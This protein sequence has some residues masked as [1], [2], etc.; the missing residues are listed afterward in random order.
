MP[1]DIETDEATAAASLSDDGPACVDRFYRGDAVYRNLYRDRIDFRA[2]AR[3]DANLAAVLKNGQIDFHDPT[4]VVQLTKTLVWRDFGLHI[5][6]PA[7]RLCPPVPNR[8][9]YILWLKGLLDSTTGRFGDGGGDD[10][11]ASRTVTGLDIG[12]GASCIYPLLGCAQRP[13]W[14]F[15]ATDVDPASL[16]C[17]R[18]NVRRN[19]LQDRICVVERPASTDAPLISLAG[20]D[21]GN[22]GGDGVATTNTPFLPAALDFVMVN[23][24]FYASEEDMQAAA[25]QKQQPP[26]SACTGTPVEMV[27]APGGEVAF[28]GRLLAESAVLRTRVAWYTSLLGRLASVAAVVGQLRAAGV[29]NYAVAAFVQGR[30]TRRWAVAWSYGA[31]RPAV[32][33]LALVGG[34]SSSIPGHDESSG[35]GGLN[36]IKHLLPPN[37]DVDAVW[38]MPTAEP[39]GNNTDNGGVS[40]LASRINTIVGALQLVSWTWDAQTLR[41]AGR[42][43]ENVWGRAW[44]RKNR[45]EQQQDGAMDTGPPE[46]ETKSS[47]TSSQAAQQEGRSVAVE[48]SPH[49]G[50]CAF[51]FVVAIRVGITETVVSCRWTEG[52]SEA[53]FQSFSTPSNYTTTSKDLTCTNMSGGAGSRFTA[54]NQTT[55]Q[56]LSTQTAGLVELSDF[57]KRR[58]EVIEQQEREAR[59]AAQAG[60]GLPD[61]SQ[62]GTPT[63]DKG[64]AS[65]ASGGE[66]SGTA[67]GSDA[68]SSGL[69]TQE[70]N[71]K[72]K[73]KKDGTDGNDGKTGKDGKD[74]R[75]HKHGKV[76]KVSKL[77]FMGDEDEGD[78]EEEKEAETEEDGTE[79]N[80]T[81]RRARPSST[82]GAG[83]PDGSGAP[84]LPV[85]RPPTIPFVFYEGANIPGGVVRVRKGDHVW[86]FLDRSRKVGARLGVGEK[87][88]SK[89]RLHWARINV[90]DL[91]LVRGNLIIPH[92]YDIYFFLIN[93]TIGPGG[94]RVFDYS[95][96]PPPAQGAA[97]ASSDDAGATAGAIADTAAAN[98]LSTPDADA[99][100]EEDF[101][102]LEGAQDDPSLTKVVDRRWYERNKHIYPA[103]VWQEF[104]PEADYTQQV[105]RDQGG[106]AFFFAKK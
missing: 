13:N 69:A 57:R 6:L 47:K 21:D 11:N 65:G 106:N 40:R 76:I 28:V 5:V 60:R 38:S 24:P 72:K 64:G 37:T 93:K 62:T 63:G 23:P 2:L 9:N 35:G 94:E 53:I 95:T 46:E 14:R 100:A 86:L 34:S 105:R 98:P 49:P 75:K 96:E 45:R 19:G 89:A 15:V 41:G 7:D 1:S 58:A 80:Q 103:S 81:T 33:Q 74:S 97:K 88:L 52:H 39:N 26:H 25:R 59:E 54:Q 30:K 101:S 84:P 90:D 17:A 73:R 10:D 82:P 104:D 48:E 71:K 20:G 91:L 29:D 12:T 51:G 92:H 36:A 27:Y 3:E 85:P 43:R 79:D 78:V 99:A 66:G 44:R 67:G 70:T 56:R 4:A 102:H 8:H 87:K 31:R 22:G 16:A 55:H 77:S 32:R 68:E 61:R 83:S 42:A 50:E 18:A